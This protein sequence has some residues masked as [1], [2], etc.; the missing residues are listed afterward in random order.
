MVDGLYRQRTLAIEALNKT[1]AMHNNLV[2]KRL[3]I[4]PELC[5]EIDESNDKVQRV[6]ERATEVFELLQKR[7][8]EAMEEE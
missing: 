8:D 7:L 1:I 2:E 5:K 4:I 3:K 6:Y